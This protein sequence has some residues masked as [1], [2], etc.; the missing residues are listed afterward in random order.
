MKKVVIGTANFNNKYGINNT[1]INFSELKY[2][3]FKYIRK[4]KINFFDTSLNYK[5]DKNFINKLNFQDSKIIT[6]FSLPKKNKN[7]FLDNLQT[8]LLNKKKQFKIK[9]YEAILLHNVNDLNSTFKNKIIEN[10]K[11]LKK[12]RLVKKIGVSIY[13]PN[14]LKVVFANFNPDFIQAPINVFDKR[15][16]ESHWMKIIKKNKICIQARSVFL[17]GLLLMSSKDL[18]K[19]R[20]DKKLIKKIRDFEK[21]CKIKRIS[22][23]EACLQFINDLNSV[24]YLTVGVNSKSNLKEILNANKKRRK[25]DFKDFSLRNT[26]LIDPRKW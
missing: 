9:N 1:Q 14:D 22:R 21:W 25:I 3:L 8:E 26:K 11:N 16:I 2:N 24:R 7:K 19:Q 23:L 10:L 5:L 18:K 20:V 13:S 6:K 17:Q 4:K 12:K 15:L